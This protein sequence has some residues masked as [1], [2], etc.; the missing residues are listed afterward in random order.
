MTPEQYV[1]L[2][3]HRQPLT[4]SVAQLYGRFL[5]GKREKD[6][7][8]LSNKL[9]RRFVMTMGPDGLIKMLEVGLEQMQILLGH[10]PEYI[11]WLLEQGHRF[12]LVVFQPIDNLHPATWEGVL[13]AALEAYPDVAHRIDFH[14]DTIRDNPLSWFEEQLGYTFSEVDQLGRKD[15]RYITHKRFFRSQGNAV[16][17][18]AFLYFVLRLL[19]L[20]QGDGYTRT[21]QGQPGVRE[22]LHPNQHLAQLGNFAVCDLTVQ[23]P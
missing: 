4:S 15:P 13:A 6:F 14:L 11:R 5:H 23:K 22:Y 20:Y 12:R 3:R 8:R 16:D 10:K 17:T 19:E 18:R 9:D 21:H 7:I 2:L 1:Q